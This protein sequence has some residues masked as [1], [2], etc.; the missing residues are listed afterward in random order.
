[1]RLLPYGDRAILVE[2][3]DADERRRFDA[4]LER[5]ALPGVVERVPAARTVLLR[6]SHAHEVA[7]IAGALSGLDTG[8]D[9]AHAG[10][11]TTVTAPALTIE[12]VYDGPDLPEVATHLGITADEVVARHTTQGWTVEFLGFTPGFGYLVGDSGGL[13]VPRRA[14]PRTRVPVGAVGLAGPYT[15]VYPRP[16][17]GGWQLIGTTTRP[18][19]EERRDPPALLAPGARVRFVRVGP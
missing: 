15:A 7:A 17:P 11:L 6:V 13:Q 18:M 14:S 8:M 10:V 1:M 5:A 2:L 9:A 12:T 19:W 4:A 16:S 3:A